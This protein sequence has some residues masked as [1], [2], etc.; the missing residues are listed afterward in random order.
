MQHPIDTSSA[1]PVSPT[2][3]P[4]RRESTLVRL[5]HAVPP[6]LIF[7]VLGALLFW[8]H[9]TGWT[10]PKF[11]ELRGETAP[12]K[13]DWCPVHA[14]PES[15]CVECNLDLM[16]RGEGFGFCKVHGVHECTLCNPGLAQTQTSRATTRDDL[17]RAAN[18]LA[19]AERPVNNGRCKQHRRRIQFE[20]EKVVEKYGIGV[21]SV[22]TAPVVE[23]VPGTA[24]VTYD[25]TLTARLS[26]RAPGS[27]FRAFKQV[28]E[29]VKR[30]ELVALVDA[31]E[32]GRAKA[33]FLQAVVQ[34]RLETQ[35]YERVKKLAGNGVSQQEVD[36]A[37]AA[38][39]EVRIGLATAQQTLTNLGL[40]VDA[41]AFEAVT[42]EQL[43]DRLRFLGL[44]KSVTDDFDPK[45]T[46]GNL[47]P[48]V[49]PFDG[50]VATRDVVAGEVV[51]TAKVMFVVV[52]PRQMWLVLDVR[53][54]DAKAVK[55]GSPIRFRPDGGSDE[56][57][58]R[59]SWVSTEARHDTRTVKVR[60]TL[61]NADGRLKANTFGT[62]RV[63]L[64]EEPKAVV[65]PS[66]AVHYEGCCH[67]VFVRDKNYL[68]D[69][70]PKVFHTRT[71]RIG[72]RDDKQT[73]IIAGVLPGELIAVKGSTVLRSELLKNNLGAGCDCCN[74]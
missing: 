39:S 16:P 56:V 36:R 31:G 2:D 58:S 3:G 14:V 8:G 27:V 1:P 4:P 70:A 7:A 57:P 17:D 21:E 47:L 74:K 29:S 30:G 35:T 6:L 52:D 10:L 18:A 40:P 32:V 49:A 53:A 12:A 37:F 25:Q 73:E 43:P 59:V 62:G 22:W 34:A 66:E 13:E 45:T 71:V 23:A 50:V 67:V 15:V 48:I 61:P 5:A 24:E 69:G 72:A 11:S 44:P 19:F 54:E 20:S 46:T 65:V 64:R 41:A 28:G 55:P 33:A 51:D 60:A 9:R 42:N 68:L 38:V 26:A 63:V